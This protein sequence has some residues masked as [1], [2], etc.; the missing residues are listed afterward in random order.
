M[1]DAERKMCRRGGGARKRNFGQMAQS[2]GV[3][4]QKPT[5]TPLIRIAESCLRCIWAGYPVDH[6]DVSDS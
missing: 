3:E 6:H 4:F 2:R 5:A 1:A